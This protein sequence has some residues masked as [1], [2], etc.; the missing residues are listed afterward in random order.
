[1]LVKC[2]K[3]HVFDGSSKFLQIGKLYEAEIVSWKRKD[4]YYLI[5]NESGQPVQG[6][7]HISR[8]EEV[9]PS[10]I[11]AEEV[12]KQLKYLRKLIDKLDIRVEKLE[13]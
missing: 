8:F 2:I 9:F 1:M 13:P 10:E 3:T 12:Y 6:I 4:E 5:D 7:Y 11:N